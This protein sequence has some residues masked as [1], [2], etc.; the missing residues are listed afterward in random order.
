MEPIANELVKF[1]RVVRMTAIKG[2][3]SYLA[4]QTADTTGFLRERFRF[5]CVCDNT[6]QRRL[7]ALAWRQK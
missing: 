5:S 1:E 2:S 7:Q 6:R 4:Q 3:C